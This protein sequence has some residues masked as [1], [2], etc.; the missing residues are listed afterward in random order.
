MATAPRKAAATK[1]VTTDEVDNSTS[2]SVLAFKSNAET[3]TERVVLFTIDDEE[4]SV[5][6]VFGTRTVLRFLND[7]RKHSE[8]TAVLALLEKTL[9]E[10]ALEK[11][12]DWED[13]SD[14]IMGQI[15][16]LVVGLVVEE[17]NKNSGK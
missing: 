5:P 17:A 14:E 9:G 11:L 15:I 13:L 7:M 8:M 2:G 4:Y 10:D 12:L 1:P 16:D 6:A 3:K